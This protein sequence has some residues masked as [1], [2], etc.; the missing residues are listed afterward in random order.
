M[1]KA[2]SELNLPLEFGE[3]PKVQSNVK[4]LQFLPYE[5][6]KGIPEEGISKRKQYADKFGGEDQGKNAEEY[7]KMLGQTYSP[8]RCDF[9]RRVGINFN[10]VRLSRTSD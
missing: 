10:Y 3:F 8:R 1:Q 6:N 2:T 9:D 5:L 7:M 4:E